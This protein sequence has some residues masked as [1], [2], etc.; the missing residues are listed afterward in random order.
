M[1]LPWY[2]SASLRL[3]VKTNP[4]FTLVSVHFMPTTKFSSGEG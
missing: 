1:D 4:H 2:S 3:R